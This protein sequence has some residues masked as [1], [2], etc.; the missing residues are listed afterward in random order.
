MSST[1]WKTG[2]QKDRIVT[3]SAL[4]KRLSHTQCLETAD[5]RLELIVVSLASRYL[6]DCTPTGLQANMTCVSFK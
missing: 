4:Y 6:A 3:G 2:V 5:S 1:E